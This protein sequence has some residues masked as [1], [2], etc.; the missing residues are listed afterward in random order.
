MFN[1]HNSNVKVSG[2][3]K[4]SSTARLLIERKGQWF[5][6]D[7]KHGNRETYVIHTSFVTS[8]S[9]HRIYTADGKYYDISD[10]TF[11]RLLD[12]MKKLEETE[13]QHDQHP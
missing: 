13:G 2:D 12:V 10:A 4:A 5:T 11:Q 7:G 6:F 8:F 3:D 9:S 1:T